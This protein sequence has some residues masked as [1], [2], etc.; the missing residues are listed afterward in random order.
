MQFETRVA[1]KY[2][3]SKYIVM[4]VAYV[5]WAVSDDDNK[6]KINHFQLLKTEFQTLSKQR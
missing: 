3:M 2:N 5:K 1:Y 4:I 6:E